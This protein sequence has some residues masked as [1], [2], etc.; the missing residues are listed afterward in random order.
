[1][2]TP[3]IAAHRVVSREQIPGEGPCG[4][5]SERVVC[6]C[7]RSVRSI[8]PWLIRRWMEDHDALAQ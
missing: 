6:A 4:H 1:M 2:T 5:T 8:F 3:E 7:G